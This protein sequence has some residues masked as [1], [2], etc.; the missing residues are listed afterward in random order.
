[1]TKYLFIFFSIFGLNLFVAQDYKQ[2][3][4]QEVCECV[5]KIDVTNKTDNERHTQFGL[6][7]FKH[8][9]PYKK[10]LKKD[11]NIDLVS[12]MG[13]TTKM[14]EFGIQVGLLMMAECPEAFNTIMKDEIEKAQEVEDVE[15]SEMLINGK[16]TKIE[17]ENFVVFHLVGDNKVLNKFYWISNVESDID[18]PKE[19]QSLLNKKVN[20]GY[21]NT[22]IFDTKISD[23]KN[24]NVISSIKT[25]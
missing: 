16:I 19:Y 11:F 25:E 9:Q 1:M 24:L 21:Y 7:A 23:Y 22:Q 5:K 20:I 15:S 18:L 4:T 3:F 14:K 8:Y 12:D 10:E 2:K 17:K 13:N 6:C